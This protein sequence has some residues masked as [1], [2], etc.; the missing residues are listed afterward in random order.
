MHAGPDPL[1][2]EAFAGDP[3]TSTLMFVRCLA[4][5]QG[6]IDAE[7]ELGDRIIVVLDSGV[8]LLFAMNK[9]T[10]PQN[11]MPEGSTITHR[12]D[13]L[14]VFESA[15]GEERLEIYVQQI[16]MEQ[17]CVGTLHGKLVKLGSE[18]EL[19]DLLTYRMD[20]VEP[21][22]EVIEREFKTDVGPI[23]ILCYS[24]QDYVPVA[25][26]VKRIRSSIGSEVIYQLLRYM[27]ALKEQEMWEDTEPRG[28][29]VAHSISRSAKALID[30]NNMRFVRLSYEDVVEDWPDDLPP[31][32]QILGK[33]DEAEVDTEADSDI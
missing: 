22:L 1:D 33:S 18:R 16:W 3:R 13:E 5:Y 28:I 32:E 24:H 9:G 21:G 12:D 27:H 15:S 14:I 30:K 4:R 29:L 25:I 10:K 17:Q 26:E 31:V 19:S 23:D 6:R 20:L 11:W 7:L 8:V 2:P